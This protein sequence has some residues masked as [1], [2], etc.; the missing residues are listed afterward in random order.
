MIATGRKT[1]EAWEAGLND[2]P[3]V[4]AEKKREAGEK[5]QAGSL[6]HE[7][8]P[9]RESW[10]ETERKAQTVFFRSLLDI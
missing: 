4:E 10:S 8:K 7:G 6:E 3:S 2:R 9:K 1:K 5:P